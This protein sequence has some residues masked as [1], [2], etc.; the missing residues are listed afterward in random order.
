MGTEQV[1]YLKSFRKDNEA[2]AGTVALFIQ[3]EKA[4]IVLPVVRRHSLMIH[5]VGSCFGFCKQ[6]IPNN[7]QN[8]V[9]PIL[10]KL[11]I[12]LARLS[13]RLR[14]VRD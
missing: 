8:R 11:K 3:P 4:H 10:K 1:S 7:R 2:E 12:I 5:D 6:R 14:P 13:M 9:F